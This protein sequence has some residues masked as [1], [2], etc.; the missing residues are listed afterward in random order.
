MSQLNTAPA[1]STFHSMIDCL[2]IIKTYESYNNYLLKLTQNLPKYLHKKNNTRNVVEEEEEEEER[3]YLTNRETEFIFNLQMM[4]LECGI[5]SHVFFSLAAVTGCI[6]I[7]VNM[8]S[9]DR[10]L[11]SGDQGS[12][13]NM[14]CDSFLL[15]RYFSVAL[16]LCNE[17]IDGVS[18]IGGITAS[19]ALEFG[20]T[21]VVKPKGKHQA[22]IV[23]LHG[24]GDD[25]S[26]WAQLLE[27]LPLPNIKWICPTSPVQ[28]LTLY[29]GLS[30]TTWFDVIEKSE[31]ASQD[32]E[33]MDASAA[34]VLSFL[35]NEPLNVKLGVGGFSMGAATAIYSASCFARG[36]LGNGTSYSAH[37]DVVVGLSG[38]LP[39]LSNKVKGHAASLPILLCHGKG[40]DVVQFRYGEK[41]AKKL[42]SAGF[43]NLTLKTFPSLGHYIIPEE[44]DEVSSWLISNLELEGES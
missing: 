28:P 27:T 5:S 3:I 7:I 32:V 26:S 36:K 29:N 14:H 1:S 22:T 18:V 37:L 25:G 42:T 12:C 8:N 35:S 13:E 4:K 34:H 44:M 2:V 19:R 31:D 17:N 11:K 6:S 33:G 23:W 20:P 10:Y 30:T 16:L 9:T 38:W 43:R 15:L 40:D 39:D 41:S 21:Y 24:L